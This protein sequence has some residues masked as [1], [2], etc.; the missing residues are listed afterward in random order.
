MTVQTIFAD[1]GLL[2]LQRL[3]IDHQLPVMFERSLRLQSG[4]VE[5]RRA[6]FTIPV[7]AL[8]VVDIAEVLHIC[9][10]M[11]SPAAHQKSI[12]QFFSTAQFIHF[13]FECSGA[14]RI[15]KCY[16]E[17]TAQQATA[18]KNAGQLD[19][20][21]FK[22]SM[23]HCE[24]AVVSKYKNLGPVKWNQIQQAMLSKFSNSGEQQAAD[25]LLRHF[26]PK[27]IAVPTAPKNLAAHT[28]SA[29][30]TKSADVDDLRLL[31]VTEEGSH[32]T[33]HDLNVYAA[34]L[35]V[36][37]LADCLEGINQQFQGDALALKDWMATHGHQTVGHLSMGRGRHN[38]PFV[39]VYHSADI[40]QLSS[41]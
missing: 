33:S 21:G 24:I 4:T 7:A 26:A 35:K 12:E 9:R 25:L 19:F 5:S 31:Q 40:N 14:D 11:S 38:N 13:G 17:R 1:L 2:A 37:H 20:L 23:V 18:H 39:T 6:L 27:N 28:K 41:Q 8:D 10:T 32:R 16:L 29:A 22:W 30:Y 34:D 3:V 15:G 36:E